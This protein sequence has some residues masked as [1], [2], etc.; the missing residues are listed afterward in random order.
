MEP[1]L[2]GLSGPAKALTAIT[3]SLGLLVDCGEN[4][5]ELLSNGSGDQGA[6]I[7]G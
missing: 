6:P 7:T 5:R 4:E 1:A 2:E 3:G